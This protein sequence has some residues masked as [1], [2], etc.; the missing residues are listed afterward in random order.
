MQNNIM[1]QEVI[2]LFPIPCGVY[3][4]AS[5]L[6]KE[7]YEFITNEAFGKNIE[8]L[9]GTDFDILEKKELVDIKKFCMDC[10]K[11]FY[12][13]TLGYSTELEISQSWANETK[14]GQSHHEHSHRNSII[15]GVFYLTDTFDS[16]LRFINPFISNLNFEEYV[17]P[18]NY[19]DFNGET[20]WVRLPANTCILFPSA[21]RHRVEKN[22]GNHSRYSIAF[23]TFFKKD[24]QIGQTKSAMLYL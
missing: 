6:T 15:S 2:G 22:T 23:N 21:L 19:N 12:N 24:Q 3:S 9:V 11:S 17:S 5:N 8:N 16:E 4:R 1:N 7:E 10:V 20:K 18:E 14:P 13:D